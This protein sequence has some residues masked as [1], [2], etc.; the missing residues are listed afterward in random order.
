MVDDEDFDRLNKFKWY[1][2]RAGENFYARRRDINDKTKAI[3]MHRM[4]MGCTF[5]D[6]KIIDHI[7][8]NPLNNQRSNLRFCTTSQNMRNVKKHPKGKFRGVSIAYRCKTSTSIIYRAVAS[9]EGKRKTI[10]CYKSDIDAAIAYNEYIKANDP[11]ARLNEIPTLPPA[12]A[13]EASAP[14][15][16]LP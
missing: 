11:F 16:S 2:K 5:G 7:D 9:I 14:T 15:P 3:G 13:L 8:G 12:E 10:G 6:G 4:I 1:A